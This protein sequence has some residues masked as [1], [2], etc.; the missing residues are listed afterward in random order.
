MIMINPHTQDL[1]S[2]SIHFL[3]QS[4]V[5]RLQ[6]LQELGI[7]RFKFL[8]KIRLNDEN[9]DCVMRFLQNPGQMKFPNLS[10]ANLS[11][12]NLDEV[13]LIRGNL[14]EA[15]LQGSSLLNADLI[16][17]NFTKADLRKADLRG[18]TLNGTVWLDTLVDE[19]Q[20]GIGNGL[21]QQQRKDLQLRGAKFNYL[22][23]DN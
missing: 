2:Q 17:V 5:Q 3:E 12:L 6:I 4:P 13:S 19:C 23:D 11:E 10:G 1:R 16:F 8:S 9:I 14:S 15:N 7:G 21:T 22:V 20:L 18:A